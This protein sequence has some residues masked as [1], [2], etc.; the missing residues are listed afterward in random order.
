MDRPQT[1]LDFKSETWR[2]SAHVMKPIGASGSKDRFAFGF[3]ISSGCRNALL[4]RVCLHLADRD[5]SARGSRL[6]AVE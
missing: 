1:K 3:L 6:S 4:V 2:G 5:D